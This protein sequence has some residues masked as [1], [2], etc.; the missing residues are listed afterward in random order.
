MNVVTDPHRGMTYSQVV[1]ADTTGKY[2][3]RPHPLDRRA[4]VG[5]VV[6]DASI[7]RWIA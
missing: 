7:G 6:W 5:P 4:P 1:K 3:E 2:I